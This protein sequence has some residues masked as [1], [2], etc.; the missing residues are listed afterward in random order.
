MGLIILRC[1][2][3]WIE[4]GFLICRCSW[5][6]H[7]PWP[8][9][10]WKIPWRR[11][12]YLILRFR[13]LMMKAT[14][15][16]RHPMM[17][18]CY[19]LSGSLCTNERII[20]SL[21]GSNLKKLWPISGG[22]S[23]TWSLKTGMITVSRRW[24]LNLPMTSSRLVSLRRGGDTQPSRTQCLIQ[25][26]WDANP[27]LVSSRAT[28]SSLTSSEPS[29]AVGSV[30]HPCTWATRWNPLAR[31]FRGL[32]VMVLFSISDTLGE[33]FSI[34]KRW[35]R[36][37]RMS[38]GEETLSCWGCLLSVLLKTTCLFWVLVITSL[39]TCQMR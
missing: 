30:E 31:T 16:M 26:R 36:P 22:L 24:N 38:V 39:F 15:K 33:S 18:L 2:L 29:A 20:L 3:P 35:R 7:H 27:S 21:Y 17:V 25:A 10:W 34:C 28:V 23:T 4:R 8:A 32:C 1:K 13:D 12:R 9:W 19:S 14:R 11:S 37:C 6:F 5:A